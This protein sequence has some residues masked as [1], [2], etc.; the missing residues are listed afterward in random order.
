MTITL[1]HNPRCSKSH[2]TLERI[3]ARG[4]EPVIVEYLLTPP[5]EQTLRHVIGLLGV[6]AVDIARRHEPAWAT[7]G[8]DADS[9]DAS[10]IAALIRDPVLIERPIVVAGDHAVI[11]RPPGAVDRLLDG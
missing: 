1:Y 9:D 2:A 5:D 7:A 11:A 4:I 8:L 3:R 6:R 10:V